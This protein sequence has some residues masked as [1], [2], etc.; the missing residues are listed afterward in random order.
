MR[1]YICIHYMIINLNNCNYN[2][3]L[4]VRKIETSIDTA[5]RER[6]DFLIALF[7]YCI[8]YVAIFL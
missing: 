5:Q 3:I 7:N 4:I 8:I 1:K 6:R 2:I